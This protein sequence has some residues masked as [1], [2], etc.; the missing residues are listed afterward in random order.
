LSMQRRFPT[1]GGQKRSEHRLLFGNRHDPS[2][3]EADATRRSRRRS[4]HVPSGHLVEQLIPG[5]RSAG[6]A[7][8]G[9]TRGGSGSSR[10]PAQPTIPRPGSSSRL[11]R[12]VEMIE[13][14]SGGWA[15]ARSPPQGT[16]R[17]VAEVPAPSLAGRV[18]RTRCGDGTAPDRGRS[19]PP[20]VTIDRDRSPDQSECRANRMRTNAFWVTSVAAGDQGR[21]RRRVPRGRTAVS[22]IGQDE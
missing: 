21:D 22:A 7:Q 2:R 19:D 12:A 14:C 9:S 4:R 16:P 18:R 5:P 8:L 11:A 20:L 13:A 6:R 15:A 1:W 3:S 10:R 17:E